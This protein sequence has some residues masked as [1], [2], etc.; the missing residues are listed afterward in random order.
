MEEY[1]EN[2]MN[3]ENATERR[4]DTTDKVETIN[5]EVQRISKWKIKKAMK[6]MK[7]EKAVGLDDIPIDV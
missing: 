4:S 5:E 2:L 3:G 6:R 1:F 7:N